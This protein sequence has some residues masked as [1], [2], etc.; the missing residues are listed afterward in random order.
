MWGLTRQVLALV[1]Y[2]G[3]TV[4]RSTGMANWDLETE[5]DWLRNIMAMVG[6]GGKGED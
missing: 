1:L 3:E 6:N 2:V 5:M 4:R